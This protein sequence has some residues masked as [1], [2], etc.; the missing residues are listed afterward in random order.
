MGA[1]EVPT[2]REQIF[3]IGAVD[4]TTLGF[5]LG[6]HPYQHALV[7]TVPANL[8]FTVGQSDPASDWYYAQSA[9]GSWDVVFDLAA[10]AVE[11]N[12]SAL[13]TVALAGF[14]QGS[15]AGI[16]VNGETRVG[17]LTS[18]SILNDPSLYRSSTIAGE[19]HL[20]E[21]DVDA[22]AL[23]EGTNTVSFVVEQ[24]TQWRGW[25]WD[26]VILEWV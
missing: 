22:S 4:R 15:S 13:L 20:F 18:A 11:Q 26:S 24:H 5:N 16:Y 3:Q 6:G 9:I 2:G 7:D 8:T 19:W 1:W 23:T 14:S 10:D 21:F 25:L 12:R 17:N